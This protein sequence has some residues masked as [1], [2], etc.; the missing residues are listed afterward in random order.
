MRKS[1]L[2]VIAAA[3]GLLALTGSAS[4]SGIAVQCQVKAK[5]HVETF[6]AMRP[7]FRYS[8][9][10]LW[11]QGPGKLSKCSGEEVPAAKGSFFLEAW[12][13]A[14]PTCS[15]LT[16]GAATVAG[17]EQGLSCVVNEIALL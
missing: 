2:A 5:L 15:A 13:V 10:R 11:V 9:E 14:A 3:V 4:A 7:A 12:T 17:V 1:G 8:P 6:P 16:E